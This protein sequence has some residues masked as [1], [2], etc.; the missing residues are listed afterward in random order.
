[1]A[2]PYILAQWTSKLFSN[3]LSFVLSHFLSYYEAAWFS[4]YCWQVNILSTHSWYGAIITIIKRVDQICNRCP[5]ANWGEWLWIRNCHHLCYE[6]IQLV[7]ETW[8]IWKC[9]TCPQPQVLKWKKYFTLM[10]MKP[11]I[12]WGYH[13]PHHHHF[14]A[15]ILSS[16]WFN[17]MPNWHNSYAWGTMPEPWAK[18]WTKLVL[19]SLS[20]DTYFSEMT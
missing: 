10:L 20:V 14:Q 3:T 8:F 9:G 4:Y 19:G 16:T 17:S 15:Y 1:M 12:H 7:S 11:V 6:H 13:P 18:R 5:S 2:L